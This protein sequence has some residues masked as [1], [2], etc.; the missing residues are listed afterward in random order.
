M[1]LKW[2]KDFVKWCRLFLFFYGLFYTK[3]TVWCKYILESLDLE[4]I[5]SILKDFFIEC[6]NELIAQYNALIYRHQLE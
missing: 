5:R 2:I 1:Q 6:F 3:C 4:K